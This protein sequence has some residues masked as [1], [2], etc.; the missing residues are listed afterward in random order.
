MSSALAFSTA[1]RPNKATPGTVLGRDPGRGQHRRDRHA[2]LGDDV[3]VGL[4]R[5]IG[6]VDQIN[7]GLGRGAD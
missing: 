5:E 6:M 1:S 2:G 3:E 7:S 4:S